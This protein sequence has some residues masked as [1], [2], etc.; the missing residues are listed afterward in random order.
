VIV[1]ATKMHSR[2]NDKLVLKGDDNI[3]QLAVVMDIDVSMRLFRKCC[4]NRCLFL[5]LSISLSAF[6]QK[7]RLLQMRT[8]FSN[9][10]NDDNFSSDEISISNRI[11]HLM[12]VFSQ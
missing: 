12:S 7:T 2:V 3:V 11:F 8:A 10:L 1:A 5:L 9:E 6:C 4:M